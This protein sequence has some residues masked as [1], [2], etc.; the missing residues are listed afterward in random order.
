MT[1]REKQ[2]GH[3]PTHPIEQ[4]CIAPGSAQLCWRVELIAENASTDITDRQLGNAM[5]H[6][7]RLCERNDQY[8]ALYSVS[9][10]NIPAACRAALMRWAD[11]VTE[12]DRTDLTAV[13]IRVQRV[14]WLGVPSRGQGS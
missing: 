10:P 7:I 6:G 14:N 11:F 8:V 5:D 3:R 13:D 9:A 4:P 2:R 1:G 12:S